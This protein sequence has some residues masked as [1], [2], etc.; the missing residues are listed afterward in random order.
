MSVKTSKKF[1]FSIALILFLVAC[2]AGLLGGYRLGFDQGYASGNAK[3]E[4]EQPYPMAHPV[5]DLLRQTA[6]D[7]TKNIDSPDL[8]WESLIRVIQTTVAPQE[9]DLLGGPCTVATAP[10]AESLVVNATSD[11]HQAI[12]NL[13]TDLETLKP[14]IAKEQEVLRQQRAAA[15]A[16]RAEQMATLSERIGH[17]VEA[18]QSRFN[19]NGE[20]NVAV[21]PSK[22]VTLSY[23][24]QM[25][26]ALS[27]ESL[28]D[29]KSPAIDTWYMVAAGSLV[30]NGKAYIAA[31][32]QL[33]ELVLADPQNI[34]NGVLQ[35]ATPAKSP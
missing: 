7:P 5:G 15:A 31:T 24:F 17:P 19:L 30:M 1:R 26:G 16:Y 3:W 35:I 6:I 28:I 14:A 11:T 22:I 33:G 4:A 21:A 10:F 2:V 20:W 25:E 12:A 34:E 13:L 27:I 23:R 8:G 29:S 32:T 9:W 18:I